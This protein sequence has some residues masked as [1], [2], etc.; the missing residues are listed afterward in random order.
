MPQAG[1]SSGQRPGG[2]EKDALRRIRWLLNWA[3]LP[4]ERDLWIRWSPM[5]ATRKE[6]FEA[7][8]VRELLRLRWLVLRT[9]RAEMAILNRP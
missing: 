9:E 2:E 8:G 7:A 1:T 6:S 4:E 5:F 3:Y